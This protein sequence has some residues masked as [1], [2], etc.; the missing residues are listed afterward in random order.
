MSNV[1][2]LGL[3]ALLAIPLGFAAASG[4]ASPT[5]PIVF[6]A[7]RAPSVSGE[8]YR[9]DPNGHR[10]DLSKSPYQDLFPAVSTNGRTVAFVRGLGGTAR[11]YE[12]GIDGHGLV[13]LGPSLSRLSEAECNPTL[14]W[15]PGGERLAVG[16]CTP[17]KLWIVR[18]H[19][20]PLAIASAP[21]SPS[22]S[23]DGR[24]LAASTASPRGNSVVRAFS[25]SGR[26][27]WHAA[28]TWFS[29]W[30]STNLLAVPGKNGLAV[31][32]ENGQRRFK[33]S[34]HVSGFPAW[35]RDGMLVAAILG[36]RLE[37]LTQTGR[38]V[39]QKT[40]TGDHGL[41]WDGNDRLVVGGFGATCGCRAKSL[42][43]HSGRFSSASS[44]WFDPLSPD[45]KLA[46][47]TP[48]SAGA[49]S[50]VVAPPAGGSGRTYA[51]VPDCLSDG[52]HVPAASSLQFV[53]R[54][55]SVVYQSWSDV[56]DEP[57]SNLYSVP[58]GGGPARRLTNA[59]A[60]ETQ[61]AISP[62]GTEI[63]YVWASATGLSCGGCSDGIRIAG[64]DGAPQRTLTDPQD[65][66][67]DDSPS[68]SPDGRTILFSRSDCNHPGELFTI[69]AAGGTPH[70]LGL[71]GSNPAWGPS[72]IAY[73]GSD[74]P[75]SGLW[76]ANP[77][78]SDPILLAAKGTSPTWSADGRLAY[79]LGT[80]AVVGSSHVQLP[81]AQITALAWSPDGT[82]FVVTA[83]RTRDA[84]ALDVYRVRTDGSQVVRVTKNYDASGVSRR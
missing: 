34:G 36:S 63:A 65:C 51:H 26:P 9:L 72:R 58:S 13:Q 47:Y 21:L 52:V 23:P 81:F 22:W 20:R 55:R 67:F 54:S 76:T 79:L 73:V 43:I 8:I 70:D 39:L 1:R 71:A 69:P 10:V 27:L 3:A 25:P 77:D 66:N 56:C 35:S 30:S 44:R 31:Y 19:R 38:V 33:A 78:G 68:W 57:F 32:D 75:D 53:G 37:V 4:R 40:L 29:R 50:I 60:Q 46:I 83:R 48:R 64:I 41:A 2:I 5:A 24:V 84:A 11:V 80:T 12:V 6:A 45:E 59:Q 42:D 61:P 49:Y 16:A 14:A 17:N 28:G 7:D 15:Q 62:D 74:Q 82:S 18:P